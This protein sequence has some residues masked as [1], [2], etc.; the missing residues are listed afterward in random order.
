MKRKCG[1]LLII[2]LIT[3]S[4]VGCE[5]ETTPDVEVDVEMLQNRISDIESENKYLYEEIDSLNAQ[6]EEVENQLE[7]AN[8]Y[9]DELQQLLRD[10]NIE[11]PSTEVKIY[12]DGESIESND[13]DSDRTA[14]I[15]KVKD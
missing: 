3:V 1:M 8:D 14:K 4:F 7:N 15:E 6:I 10:N 9:I 12:K 2:L 5:T 11:E 13:T